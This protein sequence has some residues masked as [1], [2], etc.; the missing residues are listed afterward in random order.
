[1]DYRFKLEAL[2][3]YRV[4]QEEARQKEMAEALRLRDQ[5][6]EILAELIDSRE[7]TERELKSKQNGRITG[8]YLSIFSTYLNKLA[9]DIFVQHHKVAEAE[10][11]LDKS[12][13]ALMAAMQKRKT[14][15]KLKEKGFKAHMEKLNR[16]EEK[17]INEMAISRFTLKQ[18]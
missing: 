15:D 14:L 18:K 5:E 4:F 10:K 2:R 11:S 3:Q 6:V 1:M 17:F 9:S 13:E 12:R 7:K 16:D 8:P